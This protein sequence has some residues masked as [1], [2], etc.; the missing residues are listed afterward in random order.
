MGMTGDA[1]P[2]LVAFVMDVRWQTRDGTGQPRRRNDEQTP[3]GFP[4]AA[5]A[6]VLILMLA[7][8]KARIE[9]ESKLADKIGGA[10]DVTLRVN[11]AVGARTT[12]P[13]TVP[14]AFTASESFD[15]GMDQG[16]PVSLDYFERR[17][18][19]FDGGIASVE[20]QTK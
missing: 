18:F 11:G 5:T 17:P 14:V 3:S 15:V 8:G 16:S 9:I 1:S 4:A 6:S 7:E 12:I 20:V 13:R 10:M 19:R 2:K